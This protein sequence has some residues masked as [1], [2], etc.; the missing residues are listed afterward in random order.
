MPISLLEIALLFIL[1]RFVCIPLWENFEEVGL[2]AS[3][4]IGLVAVIGYVYF[5]G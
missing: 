4:V 3:V 1:I 5:I 2:I